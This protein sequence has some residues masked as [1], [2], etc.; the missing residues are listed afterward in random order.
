MG[1][2]SVASFSS[3]FSGLISSRISVLQTAQAKSLSE[4]SKPSSKL[5][6]D[7]WNAEFKF[8][9]SFFLFFERT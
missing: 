6:N 3:L 4:P 8:S 5:I 1:S 7:V 9:M 2:V